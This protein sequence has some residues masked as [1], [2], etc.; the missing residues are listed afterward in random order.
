LTISKLVQ[1]VEKTKNLVY[2]S[3]PFHCTTEAQLS[4]GQP[5][6]LVVSDFQG[7]PRSMISISH[8]RAYDTFY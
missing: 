6:V 5:T 7:N 3:D 2:L 4:L 8:N 1:R